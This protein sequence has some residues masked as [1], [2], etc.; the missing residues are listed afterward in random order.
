MLVHRDDGAGI[1]GDLTDG[2]L[3]HMDVAALNGAIEDGASGNAGERG[4]RGHGFLSVAIRSDPTSE[5]DVELPV[6]HVENIGRTGTNGVED[7]CSDRAM[8]RERRDRDRTCS[9][10]GDGRIGLTASLV[11]GTEAAR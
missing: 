7:E 11:H 4:K 3:V 6:C 9:T 8:R 1:E 5:S 10:R 2:H